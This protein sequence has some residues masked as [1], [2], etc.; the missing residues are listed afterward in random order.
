MC[1]AGISIDGLLLRLKDED[2]DRILS[3]N[4]KGAARLR[5]RRHEGD[6]ARQAPAA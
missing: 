2:F 3:I 1:N 4:V 6:D 5:A